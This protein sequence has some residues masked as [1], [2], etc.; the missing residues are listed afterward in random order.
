[1]ARDGTSHG[2]LPPLGHGLS[3]RDRDGEARPLSQ[4]GILTVWVNWDILLY[5]AGN[6]KP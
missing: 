1:M 4:A 3:T 6:L 2:T 5:R